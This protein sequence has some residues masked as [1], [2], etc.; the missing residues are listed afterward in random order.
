MM[1]GGVE[2]GVEGGVVS[3]SSLASLVSVSTCLRRV[4]CV[5]IKWVLVG[6]CVRVCVCMCVCSGR[7]LHSKPRVLPGAA[8]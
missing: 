4:R 1:T 5:Q 2:G 7:V 6:V 8:R 3:V